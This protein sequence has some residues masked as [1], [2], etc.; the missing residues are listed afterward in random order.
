[1]FH[2]RRLRIS[3]EIEISK[4]KFNSIMATGKEVSDKPMPPAFRKR[5]HLDS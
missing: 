3:Y 2:F 1:M 4:E 5:V